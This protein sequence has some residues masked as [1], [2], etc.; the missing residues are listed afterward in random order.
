[1]MAM[2]MLFVNSWRICSVFIGVSDRSVRPCM[3]E[4]ISEHHMQML[5]GG[6]A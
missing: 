2:G 1:M 4:D 3:E 6:L 5:F